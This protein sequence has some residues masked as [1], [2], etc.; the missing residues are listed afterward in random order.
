MAVD[1]LLSSLKIIVFGTQTLKT[2]KLTR[3][4]NQYCDTAIQIS[5]EHE[6]TLTSD[7]HKS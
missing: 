4:S 1:Y 3:W 5:N 2:L 6:Q 7:S